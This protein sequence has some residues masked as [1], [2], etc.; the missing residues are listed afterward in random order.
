MRPRDC[1]CGWVPE[2]ATIYDEEAD[3]NFIV[4]R[5]PHCGRRTP[6]KFTHTKATKTWNMMNKGTPTRWTE[7]NLII[8]E[9]DEE[10]R[11]VSF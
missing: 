10:G 5:C 7:G 3:Y 9:L 6:K 8:A 1:K 4:V 11:L 2:L